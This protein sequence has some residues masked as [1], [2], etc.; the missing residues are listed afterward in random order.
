[1]ARVTSRWSGLSYE[2]ADD[3][4]ATYPEGDYIIE[5]A[6]T[7]TRTEETSNVSDDCECDGHDAPEN[8]PVPTE[9]S[10]VAEIRAYARSHGI[11]LP[12]G[13]KKA[14]LLALL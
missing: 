1:M 14:D 10:T 11:E 3:V 8:E 4:A 2:V 9:D 7:V 13:G 12:R 5:G 6:V